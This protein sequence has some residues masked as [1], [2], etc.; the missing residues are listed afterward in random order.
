M[1]REKDGHDVTDDENNSDSSDELPPE[2][3]PEDIV[4]SGITDV[5]DHSLVGIS[6]VQI[7]RPWQSP[8]MTS[9]PRIL[10]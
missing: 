4:S 10:T 3:N 8:H 2:V 7:A 9:I 6:R 1:N 5:V